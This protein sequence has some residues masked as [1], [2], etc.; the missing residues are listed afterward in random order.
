[1]AKIFNLATLI[2]HNM[3]RLVIGLIAIIFS[4]C[5]TSSYNPTE[6]LKVLQRFHSESR[7]AHLNK[8]IELFL[9]SFADT[10]LNVNRG[11]VTKSTI[12]ANRTRFQ[13]YF[14][15]VEFVK[16]DDTAPPEY[17]I[18]ADGTMAWVTVQKEVIVKWKQEDSSLSPNDTTLFAWVAIYEKKNGKWLMTANISTNK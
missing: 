3:K 14:D 6:D 13:N 2:T 15:N 16:W 11:K 5:N 7:E 1:M 10:V 8:D 17:K 12:E 4:A 18:S 9:S